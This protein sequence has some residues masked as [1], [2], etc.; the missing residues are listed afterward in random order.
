MF[1]YLAQHYDTF[2][3]FNY[4]TMRAGGAI[5]TALLIAFLIGPALIRYLQKLKQP[6]RNDGPAKYN[7]EEYE[8]K[9]GTP[10]MG[11]ALTLIALTVSTV[12]WGNFESIFL[13]TVLG[14]T[15]GFGLVGFIDDYAKIRCKN[16]KGL[17]K[18]ARLGA[19]LAIALAAILITAW[20]TPDF[21][22]TRLIFPFFKEWQFDISYLYILFALIVII[23]S[24]NA[25][26]ITDGLDGLATMP[27]ISASV[28]LMIIAYVT[29]RIDYTEY[30]YL[31]YIP[32][33]SELTVFGGALLG[34]CL[35]FLWFNAPPAKVWMGDLGSLALGAA[36]GTMAV[37]TKHEIV[38]AIA[39]GV[40]LMT[41][42]STILQVVYYRLTGGKRLFRMAPI[43]HHFELKN[44]KETTVVIRFWIISVVLALIALSSLKLR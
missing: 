17:S 24:A 43:H 44:W 7:K 38:W 33:A 4:I 19:E 8:C 41:I 20:V 10:T 12:L 36:F 23:G 11:G 14:T 2:Y 18:R 31:P 30:L 29:G 26:N 37:M 39:G 15:L 35:G 32:Q 6:Q 5:L 13:W 40:F 25:V 9:E 42:S 16:T 22:E 34:S 21:Y 27:A 1:H 28:V 3:V